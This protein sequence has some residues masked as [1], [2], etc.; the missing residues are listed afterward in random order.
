MLKDFTVNVVYKNKDLETVGENTYLLTDYCDEVRHN[1]TRIITEVENAFFEMQDFIRKEDWPESTRNSFMH[2][3]HKLLDAANKIDRIPQNM[4]YCG[5][6]VNSIPASEYV[7]DILN[8]AKAPT[9]C[10]NK[11]GADEDGDNLLL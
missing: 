9:C 4:H 2:I 1:V 7:A 5:V 3:R 8:T 6:P 11:C 10:C